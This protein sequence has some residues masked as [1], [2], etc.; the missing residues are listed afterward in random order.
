MRSSTAWC[1]QM[2]LCRNGRDEYHERGD[3]YDGHEER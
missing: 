2:A 1:V 3:D